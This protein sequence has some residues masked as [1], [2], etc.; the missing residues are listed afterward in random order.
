[1]KSSGNTNNS[2]IINIQNLILVII[3]IILVIIK[4]Y[5]AICKV[6]SAGDANGTSR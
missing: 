5:T 3:V 6:N 4:K 1:V 2:N